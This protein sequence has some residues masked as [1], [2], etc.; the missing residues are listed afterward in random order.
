MFLYCTKS[1]YAII[2]VSV[3][4]NAPIT[5]TVVTVDITFSEI[6]L[7]SFDNEIIKKKKLKIRENF[8]TKI[9][10]ETF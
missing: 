1:N 3:T 4:Y 9:C 2:V 6:F 8:S 7:K 10:Q 5:Y